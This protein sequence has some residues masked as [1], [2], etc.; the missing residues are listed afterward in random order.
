[1]PNCATQA[2]LT[3][4]TLTVATMET[5]VE[6]QVLVGLPGRRC[7]LARER[8]TPLEN[9]LAVSYKGNMHL[10]FDPATPLLGI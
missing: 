3:S 6:P 1:M 2:P 5:T 4:H 7:R 8:S 9:G 10:P